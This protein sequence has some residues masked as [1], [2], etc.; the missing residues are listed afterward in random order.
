MI[1]TENVTYQ[2]KN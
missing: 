1:L 2:Q